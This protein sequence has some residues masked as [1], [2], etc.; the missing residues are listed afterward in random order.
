MR[1][2]C[3]MSARRQHKSVRLPTEGDKG[4]SLSELR[5]ALDRDRRSAWVKAVLGPETEGV[6]PL[7]YALIEVGPRPENWSEHV[8]EYAQCKFI[9]L[10][11]TAKRIAGLFAMDGPAEFDLGSDRVGVSVADAGR[12]MRL[13]SRQPYQGIELPWPST[14]FEVRVDDR[15]GVG[16]SGWE[17]ESIVSGHR[18]CLRCSPV[19][20][21]D[22]DWDFSPQP[23]FGGDLHR[24][25]ASQDP[26]S[27]CSRRISGRLGRRSISA[28][29][30]S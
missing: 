12:P 6:A 1:R 18:R 4:V 9:A 14:R 30:P 11:M 15:S 23:R 29:L 8:W 7:W 24:R 20:P 3:A 5:G 27:A 19:G 2:V 25:R 17:A 16:L 28:R 26:P 10:R 22:H 21:V 13:A